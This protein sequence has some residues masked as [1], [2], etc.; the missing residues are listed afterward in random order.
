MAAEFPPGSGMG[1]AVRF[2]TASLIKRRCRPD[3]HHSAGDVGT[4]SLVRGPAAK[5]RRLFPATLSD[6]AGGSWVP[7]ISRAG[8]AADRAVPD[9]ASVRSFPRKAGTLP[10]PKW[11]N[12]AVQFAQL[13]PWKYPR[14]GTVISVRVRRIGDPLAAPELTGRCDHRQKSSRYGQAPAEKPVA[15]EDQ[16]LWVLYDAELAD[17]DRLDKTEIPKELHRVRS[18]PERQRVYT[19]EEQYIIAVGQAGQFS[20]DKRDELDVPRRRDAR[21]AAPV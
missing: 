10:L 11:G 12:A 18:I 3:N 14:R 20:K 16:F 13:P 7:Q 1:I 6:T 8:A 15:F 4:G 21:G 9:A 5:Q 17:L 2:Y 19:A